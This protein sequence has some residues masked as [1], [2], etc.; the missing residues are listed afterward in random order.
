MIYEIFC[1]ECGDK[2]KVEI[3]K[4]NLKNAIKLFK[5]CEHAITH[6]CS[7]QYKVRKYEPR[8]SINRKN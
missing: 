7:G 5:E 4:N 1:D 2:R 3:P 8:K 6:K